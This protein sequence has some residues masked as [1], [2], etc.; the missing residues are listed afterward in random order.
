MKRRALMADPAVKRVGLPTDLASL[1]PDLV[2]MVIIDL[3]MMSLNWRWILKVCD[4][5][6]DS[7][8]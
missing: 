2:I 6:E 4:M 7:I 8:V 3:V 5:Q 1:L